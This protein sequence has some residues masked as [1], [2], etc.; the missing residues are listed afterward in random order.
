MILCPH[1]RRQLAM[2]GEQFGCHCWRVGGDV[3]G[4]K[5]EESRDTAQHPTVRMT[6]RPEV[7]AHLHPHGKPT[8]DSFPV[9]RNSKMRITGQLKQ[10]AGP[11]PGHVFLIPKVRRTPQPHVHR[12]APWR[13]K[14]EW[15]QGMPYPQAFAVESILVK[16]FVHTCGRIL[17]YTKYWLWTRQIKMIGQRKPEGMPHKGNSNY[18]ESVTQWLSF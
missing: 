15:Y 17:S 16:R 14:G 3:T 13:S 1:P 12:K 10:Q 18:H 4:I 5:W 7:D 8:G 6:L 2:C 9:D 11:C